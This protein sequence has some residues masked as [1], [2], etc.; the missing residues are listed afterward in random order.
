MNLGTS[1]VVVNPV[2]PPR[3]WGWVGDAVLSALER[4]LEGQPASG[5]SIQRCI[6]AATAAVGKVRAQLIEAHL[7]VDAQV[8][9][10]LLGTGS[11][12]IA[13]T[14]GVRL[15]RARNGVPERLY[16]KTGRPP[17]IA[18][19]QPQTSTE[20][21][22]PGDLFVLGTRDTFTVRAIGNLAAA[23]ARSQRTPASELCEAVMGPCRDAGIGAAAAVLRAT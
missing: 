15:Y 7:T 10:L 8:G 11:A 14:S 20:S 5:A 2:A 16:A 23:L 1:F 21:I 3:L 12:Y 22:L 6:E 4:S 18:T 19:G 9:V 13:L 17:G